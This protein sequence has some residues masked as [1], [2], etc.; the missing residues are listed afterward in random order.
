VYTP[1]RV[2]RGPG[3]SPGSKGGRTSARK[4]DEAAGRDRHRPSFEMASAEKGIAMAPK[5]GN[6]GKAEQLTLYPSSSLVELLDWIRQEQVKKVDRI[7]IITEALEIYIHKY[8]LENRPDLA[9]QTCIVRKQA[10]F[11][12]LLDAI[13]KESTG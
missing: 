4:S 9:K 2:Y 13:T 11:T 5:N 10:F 12:Q 7:D 1:N 8:V 3:D 6:G